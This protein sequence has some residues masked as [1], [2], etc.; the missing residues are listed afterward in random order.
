MQ[1][2]NLRE[3]AAALGISRFA[4]PSQ[5]L[6]SES[7]EGRPTI[8]YQEGLDRTRALA[9]EMEAQRHAIEKDK[10]K[11]VAIP[12]QTPAIFSGDK[13]GSPIDGGSDDAG[14]KGPETK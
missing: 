11:T 10:N 1:A 9:G 14:P 5:T 12:N 8:T 7:G 13:Q 4:R 6:G 3:Q 2:Q